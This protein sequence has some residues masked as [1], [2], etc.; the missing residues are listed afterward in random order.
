ML[1]GKG[2]EEAGCTAFKKFFQNAPQVLGVFVHLYLQIM[3]C[4]C[5]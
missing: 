2:E 3:H 5:G 4:L 1:H